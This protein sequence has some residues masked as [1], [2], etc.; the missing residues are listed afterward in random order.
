M[1][2]EA[3]GDI[4]VVGEASNGEEAS[5]IAQQ[6]QPEV[7]VMDIA[8]PGD[9]LGATRKL[10]EA[11][12]GVKVVILTMM[13][14][15]EYFF[16]AL[17][18]GASGYVLKEATSAD[19]VAALRAVAVGGVFL[20]PPV[21]RRLVESYLQRVSSGE[22]RSSY[23]RLSPRERDVLGLIAQGYTNQEIGERLFISISTVQ[24]HRT[25]LME[26]LNLHSRSDLIRYAIQVGLLRP[27]RA[28]GL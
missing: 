2:L 26:K 3:Q 11:L 17:E 5:Q 25:H 10:R 15:D 12:P 14:G 24:T 6:C 13:G 4:Q 28:D 18:A 23:E 19:L 8:M 20:Y 9:G 1:L 22:E 21:A 27:S 7:V 16:R